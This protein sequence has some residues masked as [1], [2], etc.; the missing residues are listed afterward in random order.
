MKNRYKELFTDRSKTG[1]NLDALC[2]KRLTLLV[3][4]VYL[5]T[6]KIERRD[7][8]FLYKS[9]WKERPRFETKR[10]FPDD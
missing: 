3:N 6:I 1:R 7:Q 10:L 4:V 8:F 2:Y 9:D 5:Y